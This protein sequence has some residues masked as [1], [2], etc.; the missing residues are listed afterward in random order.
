MCLIDQL[1]KIKSCAA[2]FNEIYVTKNMPDLYDVIILHNTQYGFGDISFK[3]K[4]YNYEFNVTS[5]PKCICGNDLLISRKYVDGYMKYCSKECSSIAK[6]KEKIL[7]IYDDEYIINHIKEE[8][9]R[10]REKYIID[11]FD[12]FHK[13]VEDYIASNNI[14]IN[15]NK[16]IFIQKLYYYINSICD[17]ITCKMCDNLV[18]FGDSLQ[19]GFRP[20]CSAKCREKN[21]DTKTKRVNTVIEKYGVDN[22]AKSIEVKDKTIIT[23]YEKYGSKSS[24]QNVGVRDKWK[25]TIQ[26]R[27]GVDHIF[28]DDDI[29][30]KIK[31]TH[32]ERYGGWYTKSDGYIK[33]AIIT[34]NAKYGKDWYV[35]TDEYIKRVRITNNIKYGSNSYLSS[36]I[37][38]ILFRSDEIKNK[39]I[40]STFENRKKK[41]HDKYYSEYGIVL[42]NANGSNLRFISNICGHVFDIHYDSFI[43]RLSRDMN[44]CTECLKSFELVSKSELEVQLF[45]Y[46]KSFNLYS[47]IIQSY[48]IPDSR[49]TIDIFIPDINLGIEFKGLY[50][51]GEKKQSDNKYHQDKTLL[52]NDK[53]IDLIHIFEDDWL[54]KK[55]IVKSIISNKL[56]KTNSIIY[57]RK[58]DIRIVSH[59]EAKDFLNNNHMQG[60]VNS[61]HRIGLYYGD[62]LVSLM[63][64]GT[65]R[66]SSNE[67]ELLRFANI[68]NT[69]VVGGASKLFK[70]YV[71][72]YYTTNIVSYA[73]IS[74]FNGELYEKLGFEYSHLSA[75]NYYWVG[76]DGIKHHRYNFRKKVLLKKNPEYSHLTE[77]EIMYKLG[78]YKI[79]SCG[80]K[81]YIFTKK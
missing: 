28:Q 20:Y 12:Y 35:R 42:V 5:T 52:C 9:A 79:Y 43:F 44:V 81:K 21:D 67:T 31:T 17:T 58:C 48:K 73:D 6:K 34:N 50:W 66:F 14:Q 56:G 72:N 1:I 55:D 74:M 78:Y 4:I 70:Y 49:K 32:D 3:T 61:K 7:V 23:N 46:I 64:F 62:K 59:L 26:D 29:K 19:V 47:D 69:S 33:A 8:S 2:Y 36:D 18:S 30:D 75:P 38:K 13:K 22:V 76:R 25:K 54:Y 27:Y 10:L 80:Q 65:N 45:D 15:S 53:G 41:Y 16:D 60:S 71:N 40:N 63:T 11:N 24:F 51:H 39:I 77:N 57:A 68:I 37:R